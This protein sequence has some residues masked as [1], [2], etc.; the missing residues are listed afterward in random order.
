MTYNFKLNPL[1]IRLVRVSSTLS[2][3]PAF[4]FPCYLSY[5][6]RLEAKFHFVARMRTRSGKDHGAG[7]SQR[8]IDAPNPSPT[9]ALDDVVAQLVNVSTV[10]QQI[11]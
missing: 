5:S 1:C 6:G 8:N 4:T 9:S 3:L 2:M 10:L 11:A 7:A